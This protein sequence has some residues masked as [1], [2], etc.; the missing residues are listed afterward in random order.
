MTRKYHEHFDSRAKERC[1][2]PQP[3]LNMIDICKDKVD[4]KATDSTMPRTVKA[5]ERDILEI[6][7]QE[8]D[9][10]VTQFTNTLEQ[11]DLRAT[12]AIENQYGKSTLTQILDTTRR[13]R[14]ELLSFVL[15]EAAR[16]GV[17]VI[18]TKIERH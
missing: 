17:D 2:A 6:S 13:D 18:E 4:K 12:R 7:K 16:L 8:S 1:H 11:F 9:H 10:I 15:R 3:H 5:V 14:Y